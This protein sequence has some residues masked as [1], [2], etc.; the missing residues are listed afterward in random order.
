MSYA[1]AVLRTMELDP[2]HS[3]H[4]ALQ[5]MFVRPTIELTTADPQSSKY[6]SLALY[7][8]PARNAVP[9]LH[10]GIAC[11]T[12]SPPVNPLMSGAAQRLTSSVQQ[13][14]EVAVVCKT[15]EC[16]RMGVPAAPGHRKSPDVRIA[17]QHP[18]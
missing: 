17:L 2:Q 11:A 4:V 7:V 5:D 12:P 18:G 1:T 15:D 8:L 10:Q 6:L 9:L 14:L 16:L 3:P 13:P